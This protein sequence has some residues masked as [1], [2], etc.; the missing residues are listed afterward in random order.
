MIHAPDVG[1]T[2]GLRDRAILA[3]MI[4]CG[5]RREEVVRLDVAHLQQREGRW[6]IL[7]LIGKHN[8]TRTVPMASWVK[9]I[10]INGCWLGL[11]RKGLYSHRYGVAGISR[12]SA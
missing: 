1:T 4:G 6:V 5:L 2:K 11:S 8:R 12:T 7:D 9:A 3:V 10:L